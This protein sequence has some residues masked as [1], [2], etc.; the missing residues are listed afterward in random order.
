MA[1]YKPYW[2]RNPNVN[3]SIGTKVNGS[4]I[5]CIQKPSDESAYMKH[6][7]GHVRYENPKWYDIQLED[8]R[9]ITS[10]QLVFDKIE[11]EDVV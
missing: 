9:W 7:S 2:K 3:Y 8:G 6:W 5:I 11:L 4:T 10:N 1:K